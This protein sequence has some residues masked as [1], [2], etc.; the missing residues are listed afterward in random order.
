[1]VCVCVC[2]CVSVC[3]HNTS[4][5]SYDNIHN[6]PTRCQ[7]I[8]NLTVL[9]DD[10]AQGTLPNYMFLSPNIDDDGHNTNV[11]FAGQ[12]LD[13]FLSSRLLKFPRGTLVVVTWDEVR[14]AR[15]LPF[16]SVLLSSCGSSCRKIDFQVNLVFGGL[17]LLHSLDH[18]LIHTRTHTYTLTHT[19]SLSLSLSLSLSHA[20]SH[21]LKG[22]HSYL[23]L[24]L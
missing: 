22:F 1:M 19:H 18:S 3:V 13:G 16:P 5:I 23:S 12:W 10:L 6:N 2:V 21:T 24:S 15:L 17:C 20:C 14:V 8:V 4:L 9:D 11:Q 7:N